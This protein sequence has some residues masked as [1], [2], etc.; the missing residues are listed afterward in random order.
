MAIALLAVLWLLAAGSVAVVALHPSWLPV[1]GSAEGAYVDHQMA[2]SISVLL[3][4]FF[5]AHG[6][7][8]FFVWRWRGGK[9]PTKSARG[10]DH[11]GIEAGWTLATLVIFAG[12][13]WSGARSLAQVRAAQN[14]GDGGGAPLKIEVTGMQFAWY[15]HYPGADGVL[16]PT[17]PGLVDASAGNAGAIGLDMR[18]A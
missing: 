18:A 10:K 15:F 8:G 2:V 4:L 12:L 13:A 16:G 17:R 9:S 7:L 5:A 14:D 3:G 11:F 6:L 1:L